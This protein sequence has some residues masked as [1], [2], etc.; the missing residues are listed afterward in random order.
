M[1]SLQEH[2]IA[3]SVAPDQQVE[4]VARSRPMVDVISAMDLDG[5]LGAMLVQIRIDAREH[6]AKQVVAPVNIADRMDPAARRGR[7]R[8]L[9]SR[10]EEPHEIPGPFAFGASRV[11]RLGWQ[12]GPGTSIAAEVISVGVSHHFPRIIT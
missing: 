11:L 8:R 1:I 12:I 5:V 7:R 4:H 9:F 10:P 6:V 3:C 2:G